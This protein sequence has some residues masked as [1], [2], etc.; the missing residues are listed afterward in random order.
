MSCQAPNPFVTHDDNLLRQIRHWFALV[1]L[2]VCSR[3]V[4]G[5][6]QLRRSPRHVVIVIR[7]WPSEFVCVMSGRSDFAQLRVRA[8]GARYRPKVQRI[9]AKRG[10]LF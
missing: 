8:F 5:L 6:M 4:L 1:G 2:A 3:L 7:T 10:R 9:H